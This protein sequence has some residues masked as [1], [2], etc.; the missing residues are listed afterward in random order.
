MKMPPLLVGHGS[1]MNAI[2]QNELHLD[3]RAAG[4]HD[5]K[6]ITSR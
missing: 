1:P 4:V 3:C 6:M 5:K 2:E